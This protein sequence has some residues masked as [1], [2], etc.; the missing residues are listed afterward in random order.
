[1]QNQ[2]RTFSAAAVVA[3]LSMPMAAHADWQYTKWGMN[4]QEVA[5]ASRE[6]LRAATAEERQRHKSSALSRN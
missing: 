1:M 4:V 6:A 3:V 5:R 2:M